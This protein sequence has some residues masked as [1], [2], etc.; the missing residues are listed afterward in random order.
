MDI[1][2]TSDRIASRADIDI[3]RGDTLLLTISRVGNIAARSDIWFT[4]KEN[5]SDSD[6]ESQIQISESAGLEYINGGAATVPANGSVTVTDAALGNFTIELS[7][8]ETAK[9]ETCGKMYH[10][11]QISFPTGVYTY[12]SGKAVIIGDVTR[13]TS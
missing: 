7:A 4:V 10:D 12:A 3:R 2:I 9:L 13:A 8:D 5:R 6:S 11:I 1:S